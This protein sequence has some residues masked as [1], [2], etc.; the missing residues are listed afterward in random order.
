MFDYQDSGL[1]VHQGTGAI[2]IDAA[3]DVLMVGRQTLRTDAGTITVKAGGDVQMSRME[4]ATGDLSL[5]AL[6]RIDDILVSH[7]H[8]DHVLAIGLLA[9]SVIRPREAA[10]RP[11][12]LVRGQTSL[13]SIGNTQAVSGSRGCTTIVKPTSPTFF[14]IALPI[15]TQVFDG[16]SMR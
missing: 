11:P 10:G 2:E 1:E 3:G 14:G 6:A 4:S 8:L 5:E 16:R 9:D 13:P 15:R 12:G 7:A